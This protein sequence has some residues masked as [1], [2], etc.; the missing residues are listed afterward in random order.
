MENQGNQAPAPVPQQ[1]AD[2][3]EALK[4]ELQ[5]YKDKYVRALAEAE[6]MRKR[7]QK[8]KLESQSFAIQGV[9]VDFLQPLDHFEQALKAAQNASSEI[10]NWVFGFQMI[11]TQCQQVLQDNGVVP[12]DSIGQQFDPHVHEAIETLETT[13]HPEGMIIEEFI[14]GYKMGGNRVL[15]PAKVKVAVAPANEKST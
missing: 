11:L 12:F 3:I 7:M 8:E 4:A 9:V 10:K 15:R 2:T 13:E 1:E 5:E 6:N 14:R